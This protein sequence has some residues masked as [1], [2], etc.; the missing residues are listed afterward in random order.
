MSGTYKLDGQ[1][2]SKNPI[3]K[4]WQRQRVATSGVGESIYSNFWR[5]EL[6][7]GALETNPDVAY[8]EDRFLAGGLHTAILP[9]PKTG[10]LTGFTGVNIADFN[11]EFTDVDSDGWGEGGRMILDHISLSATGTV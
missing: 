2:F 4:R 5:I 3:A 6:S 10:E 8:F 7:F 1:L 11:Y 9:H